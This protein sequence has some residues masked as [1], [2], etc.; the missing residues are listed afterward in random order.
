MTL[1]KFQNTIKGA[2]KIRLQELATGNILHIPT[3]KSMQ[4]DLGVEEVIQEGMNPLAKMVTMGS[5]QSSEKPTLSISF[6]HRQPEALELLFGRKFQAAATL[7]APVIR[8]LT[9][10]STGEVPPV[11]AT[12]EGFGIIVDEPNAKAAVKGTFGV[13]KQLT[14]VPWTVSGVVAPDSWMIGVAGALRFP[15]DLAGETVTV[16]TEE[17]I[18]AGLQL[19]D[20]PVGAYRLKAILV[21]SVDNTIVTFE[22]DNVSPTISGN[23]F[24][25]SAADV[26]I[27]FRL[28][29]SLGGC[30]TYKIKYTGRKVAC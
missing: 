15:L 26:P 21:H 24:D 17:P 13:S 28:D 25:P 22:A 9:I 2:G 4:L 8:E 12:V 5:Y 18:V 16:I 10:P 27:K 30:S 29:Q 3:P 14:R 1:A 19:G 6:G 7:T 11:V 20:V 23:S